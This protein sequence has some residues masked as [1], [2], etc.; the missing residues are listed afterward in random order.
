[1]KLFDDEII[2]YIRQ[3]IDVAIKQKKIIECDSSIAAFV[4]Y[5][6]YI[7]LMYEWSIQNKELDEKEL[8][9]NITKILRDGIFLN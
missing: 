7:S 6:V 8:S 2:K 4:I 5:R 3:K 1:M 9:D